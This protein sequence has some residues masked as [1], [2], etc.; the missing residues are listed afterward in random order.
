MGVQ[1][2]D[3]DE[4]IKNEFARVR[5]ELQKTYGNIFVQ[6]GIINE[7]IRFDNILHKSSE[8]DADMRQ[9]RL[10]MQDTIT[11]KYDLSLAFRENM[12]Q[13]N[14]IYDVHKT[15]DEL[16][17]EMNSWC[18]ERIR[19]AIKNELVFREAR[20]DE[21]DRFYEQRN[22]L[23][24]YKWFNPVPKQ[25]YLA[26]IKYIND[27]SCWSLFI[28]EKDG[29]L[30]AWSICVY[31]ADRIIY[32]YGF[33]NR[34]Y[35]NIGGHHFLKFKI[36]SRAREKWITTCDMMGWAPTWFPEHPLTGVSKFKES[37]GGTKIEMFGSYDLVLRP[38]WY[39]I[40]KRVYT[41]R[42]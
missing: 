33:S 23:S 7:I 34:K 1:L 24:N 27:N 17:A 5:K 16:L 41:M 37:L 35:S 31:D 2:P 32:L 38:L 11:K 29:D 3:D 26:L 22:I 6:F 14:I 18:K 8:F 28:A 9:A 25:D 10:D 19:K 12:P 4:R 30:V 15:D 20:E 21:Y 40:M 42:K 36:F 13:S 39:R